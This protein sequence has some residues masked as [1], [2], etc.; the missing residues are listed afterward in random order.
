[1]FV[2]VVPFRTGKKLLLQIKSTNPEGYCTLKLL[3][4]PIQLK[5]NGME[6]IVT[7]HNKR[8]YVDLLASWRLKGS[9]Y[10]FTKIDPELGLHAL[11]NCAVL[12][13]V[14]SF[15]L[16]RGQG[17]LFGGVCHVLYLIT[18]GSKSKETR[19]FRLVKRK[20]VQPICLDLRTQPC[21]LKVRCIKGCFELKLCGFRPYYNLTLR[22][23]F[24]VHI[25]MYAIT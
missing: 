2:K 17:R 24:D 10:T 21:G 7:E 8:E 12:V 4:S 15:I 23:M 20:F 13:Y 1:M 6:T 5:N 25:A 16:L 9:P 18:L 11:D 19:T 3:C 14:S 22:C